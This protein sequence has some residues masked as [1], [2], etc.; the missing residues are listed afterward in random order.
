MKYRVFKYFNRVL[1]PARV[2][3][4]PETLNEADSGSKELITKNEPAPLTKSGK[5]LRDPR[6]S[7]L[8]P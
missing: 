5:V 8:G 2:D 6:Q 4:A 7:F 1:D 3:T